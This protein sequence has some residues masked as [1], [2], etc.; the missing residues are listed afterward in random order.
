VTASPP[1]VER[2][3]ARALERWFARHARDLPWRRR[4]TGYRALVAEIM[5]QQTQVARVAERYVEFLRRFPTVKALAA[6]DEQEVLAAWQGLGYYRRAR[7]LHAAARFVVAEMGGRIPRSVAEL[8]RLPG[9]GRYTA[10]AIASIV[11]GAPV[12][13]VDGNVQR[14][15]ARWDANDAP[16]ADAATVAATWERAEQ[17]VSAAQRP[18]VLNEALMELGA[19]VCTPAN[20]RCSSCPVAKWCA[21]RASDRQDSIPPPKP[22]PASTR[23]HHHVVVV[24]RGERILLE[25]RPSRGLWSNLWQAPTVEAASA[26]TA[27]QVRPRLPVAVTDVETLPGFE[28]RTTHRRIRFHVFHARSRARRGTWR[29]P[30]DVGDLPMSNAQRRVLALL[31][32]C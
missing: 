12:P 27:E 8:R 21:A 31:E 18:G 4:R 22:P 19:T 28:Y 6:A 14:V 30:D 10:G 3:R 5:L 24:R 15:I 26:L 7:S 11:Y 32:D 25:Q 9:V 1:A 23:V 29:R 17:V 20:P 2:H 16:P 13:I